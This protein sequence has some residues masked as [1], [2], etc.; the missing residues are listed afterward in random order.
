M[1]MTALEAYAVL[2]LA[3]EAYVRLFHVFAAGV[4]LFLLF[5]AFEDGVRLKT[6]L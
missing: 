5:E 4:V 6:H 1:K 2:S 3:S